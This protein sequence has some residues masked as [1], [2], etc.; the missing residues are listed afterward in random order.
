M[1]V[2]T[3]GK[4]F[5]KKF[6]ERS[7]ERKSNIKGKFN[8]VGKSIVSIVNTVPRKIYSMERMQ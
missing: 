1:R 8:I 4:R 6:K 2:H 7:K 3:F 5:R